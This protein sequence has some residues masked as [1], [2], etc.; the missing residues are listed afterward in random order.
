MWWKVAGTMPGR[1]NWRIKLSVP[2]LFSNCSTPCVTAVVCRGGR[3][4]LHMHIWLNEVGMGWLLSRLS[5]GTYWGNEIT[6]TDQ[7]MLVHSP[8]S[9]LHEPVWTDPGLKRGVEVHKLIS[10]LKTT[11]TLWIHKVDRAQL[12]T[13]PWSH[14]CTKLLQY[15][16]FLY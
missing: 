14:R 2:I 13:E 4:H 5:V 16:A 6:V 10:T 7:G 3:L 15:V 11:T 12:F 8:L 1:N 9:W